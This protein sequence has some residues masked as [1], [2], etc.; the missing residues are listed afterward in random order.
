MN[1]A[2]ASGN[3]PKL[4]LVGA[5]P[6]ASDL[7]T[8]RGLS[9][10]KTADIILYDAL[11]SQE[12]LTTI[13]D[14][15][16]KICVGKRAGKHSYSQEEIN[17]L[18]VESAFEYGH[19]VR[20]KGGDPFVFGRGYEEIEYAAKLGIESEV[21]PG[22]SSALAVPANANIPLTSRN[23][24]E[25]FWVVT[26]TTK[27]GAIS[28]D[29]ALAAQSTATVVILMGLRKIHEIMELFLVHGKGETPVAV[30]QN[31]TLPNERIIIGKVCTIADLVLDESLGSPAIIVV[32]EVVHYAHVTESILHNHNAQ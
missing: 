7:I 2:P 6:G 28:S 4:T 3:K 32:G 1:R 25:S 18:I 5:G 20:L 21:V 30:I 27:A 19:V 11:V 16:P 15:I 14:S 8:L 9:V 29:I 13:P 31:G 23:V 12:I 24:S 26:G 10:L 17:D 22:V